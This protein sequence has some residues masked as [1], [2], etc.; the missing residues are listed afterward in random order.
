M[1]AERR[2]RGLKTDMVVLNREEP[3]QLLALTGGASSESTVPAPAETQS[4]PGFS[5]PERRSSGGFGG[6]SR[7]EGVSAGTNARLDRHTLGTH[8]AP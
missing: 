7:V 2:V 6:S 4:G 5:G 8:G 3:L 1:R